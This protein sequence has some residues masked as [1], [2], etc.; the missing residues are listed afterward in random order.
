MSKQP[1]QESRPFFRKLDLVL[2]LVLAI[3]AFLPLA[4]IAKD[5]DQGALANIYVQNQLVEIYDLTE[6]K[7]GHYQ[8]EGLEDF[9]FEAD[10][11]GG[12]GISQA[13]CPDQICVQ[14]AFK[15]KAGE[16]IICIPEQVAVELIAKEGSDQ[17]TNK[18]DIIIGEADE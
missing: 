10:G 4:L 17:D 15:S 8:I 5:S 7:A 3:L 1:V 12:F 13:P 9:I 14:A 18:N 11:R 2:I 16:L 6:L